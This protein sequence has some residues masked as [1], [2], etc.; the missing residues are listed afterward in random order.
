MRHEERGKRKES[1]LAYR[2]GSGIGGGSLLWLILL[3]LLVL[4]V[5]ALAQSPAAQRPAAHSDSDVAREAIGQLRSPYCPGLMLEVCPSGQAEM[6]RDSIRMLAQ[7]G[8]RANQIVEWMIA[9]HG[10]EW[11]AVPKRSGAG[12]WA[13]VLPPLA[14]LFGVGLVAAKLRSMRTR[15]ET[16][17]VRATEMTDT[18]RDRLAA[19]LRE[20]EHAEETGE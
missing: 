10:E 11:R 2:G 3:L 15:E 16:S 4:A 13:W 6:L 7:Q 1:L 9:N 14:L 18:D 20:W 17:G 5:P 19:A 12:L 8:Q